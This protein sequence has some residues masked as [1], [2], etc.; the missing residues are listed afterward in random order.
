[1]NLSLLFIHYVKEEEVTEGK[2]LPLE[3]VDENACIGH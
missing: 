3:E 1:V 2:R